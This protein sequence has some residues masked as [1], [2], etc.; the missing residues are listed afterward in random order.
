MSDENEILERE[1]QRWK[2][3]AGVLLVAMTIILGFVSTMLGN[4]SNALL[5][6]TGLFGLIGIVFIILWHT[7]EQ[8][9]HFP[10]KKPALLF[11]ASMCFGLQV[12]FLALAI[13]GVSI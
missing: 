2:D 3:Y 5:R 9:W 13:L 10:P 8:V 11:F 1:Y 4:N 12:G 7:R 6:L